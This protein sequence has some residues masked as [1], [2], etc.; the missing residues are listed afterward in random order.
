MTR[1]DL[2][3]FSAAPLWLGRSPRVV[4]RRARCGGSAKDG[5]ISWSGCNR[6]A[7]A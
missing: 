6:A 7:A 1:R 5:P 2:I 3:G 4:S